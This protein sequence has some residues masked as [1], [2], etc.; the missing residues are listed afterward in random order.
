MILHVNSRV[1]KDRCVLRVSRLGKVSQVL[2]V[3]YLTSGNKHIKNLEGSTSVP[4]AQQQQG[5]SIKEVTSVLGR[6]RS[7]LLPHLQQRSATSSNLFAPAFYAALLLPVW[8]D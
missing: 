7:I 1:V 6:W 5:C 4:S 8:S 3:Q 2:Q